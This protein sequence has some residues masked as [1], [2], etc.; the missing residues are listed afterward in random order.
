MRSL[1]KPVPCVPDQGRTRRIRNILAGTVVAVALAG[2]AV[3]LT[4]DLD[5]CNVSLYKR[6]RIGKENLST[7]EKMEAWKSDLRKGLCGEN[8]PKVLSEIRVEESLM[9]DSG[10][11]DDLDRLVRFEDLVAASLDAKKKIPECAKKR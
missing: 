6:G 11:K 7:P 2:A 3:V 1:T 4:E 5:S 8:H 9:M 10:R